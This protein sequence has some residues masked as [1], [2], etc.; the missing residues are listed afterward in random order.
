MLI[1]IQMTFYQVCCAKKIQLSWLIK[2]QKISSLEIHISSIY[3]LCS[4]LY[5]QPFHFLFL[6][7]TLK[8]KQKA[9]T[10]IPVI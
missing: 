9:L 2:V 3:F 7:D 10:K 1:E 5:Q 6:G 8:N 4:S